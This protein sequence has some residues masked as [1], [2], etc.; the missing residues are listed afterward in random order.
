MS[1]VESPTH[2]DAVSRYCA[3]SSANDLEGMLDTLAPNAELISPLSANLVIR[4]HE[5]LRVLLRAI[6][7][8]LEGLHWDAPAVNGSQVYV[9][10]SSRVAGLRVDDAMIFELGPDGS[11]VRLRPHLRPWLGTTVLALILGAKLAPHFGVVM[12]ALR[13]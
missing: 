9:V 1:T 2:T 12:R 4:G 3:A 8:S 6:Y 7:S 11:I 10:G 13:T 5:D